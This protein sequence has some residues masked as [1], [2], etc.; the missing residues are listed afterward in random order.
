MSRLSWKAWRILALS[1]ADSEPSNRTLRIEFDISF[2]LRMSKV[3][4]QAENT[5]LVE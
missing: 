3:R 4:V 1:F 2:G 5:T